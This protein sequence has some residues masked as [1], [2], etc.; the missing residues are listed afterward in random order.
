MLNLND[1]RVELLQRDFRRHLRVDLP[2]EAC[3]ALE[4]SSAHTIP[5]GPEARW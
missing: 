5:T 2:Q 3:K 1:L 4:Q